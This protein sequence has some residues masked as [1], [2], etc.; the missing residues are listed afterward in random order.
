MQDSSSVQLFNFPVCSWCPNGLPVDPPEAAND[1][2]VLY[3]DILVPPDRVLRQPSFVASLARRVRDLGLSRR[4]LP[5]FM[6]DMIFGYRGRIIA[7]DGQRFCVC[8]VDIDE[9]FGGNDASFRWVSD[10]LRMAD[11]PPK[12]LAQSRII[13]RLRLIALALSISGLQRRDTG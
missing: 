10:F 13:E 7:T 11:E 6:A 5:D 3:P 2:Q 1:N 4:A 12:Q 9:A 8:R